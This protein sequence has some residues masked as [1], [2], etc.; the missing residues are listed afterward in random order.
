MGMAGI[1]GY[2]AITMAT[3]AGAIRV[4]VTFIGERSRCPCSEYYQQADQRDTGKN[5]WHFFGYFL[6]K[7]TLLDTLNY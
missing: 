2:R 4:E 6:H 7:I 3:N 5:N 1:A